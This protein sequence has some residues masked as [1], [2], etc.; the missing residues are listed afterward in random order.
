MRVS[1]C[2]RQRVPLLLR[3]QGRMLRNQ[4]VLNG[5]DRVDIA[6]NRQGFFLIGLIIAQA[7]CAAFFLYDVAKDIFEASGATVFYLFM[8]TLATVVLIVAA[9]LEARTL[10]LLVSERAASARSISIARGNIQSVIDAYFVDWTL[11]PAEIDVASLT[12]KGM[13]ISEI[14]ELRK[15]REGTVKTHLNAI[16]RKAGISGRAQLISMLIE[17]LMDRP[18][19]PDTK[20]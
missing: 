14:A 2:V 19:L 4:T 20:G 9:L 1:A 5:C 8:E 10:R 15:S 6:K 18:M 3:G 13:S 17:D 7:L 11:T 12:I 16:Y